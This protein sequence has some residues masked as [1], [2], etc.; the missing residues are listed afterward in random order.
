MLEQLYIKNVALIDEA[1]IEFNKGLNILSGETG[2]GKSIIIGSITFVLG[3]RATKDFIKKGCEQARVEA[4]LS[5]NSQEILNYILEMGI[6]IQNDNSILISRIYT[7]SGRNICKINGK[8]V[9]ISM[10]KE[11][12]EKLIDIHGQ[13]EHQ[14]L[15]NSKKHIELLDKFCYEKLDILKNDLAE[16][17]IEYKEIKIFVK[18]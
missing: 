7:K 14:S 8:P 1:L 3:A 5:I 12:S 11:I 17:I 15:L 2:A 10:I 18:I 6:D 4:L 16:Y 9:T 13:H